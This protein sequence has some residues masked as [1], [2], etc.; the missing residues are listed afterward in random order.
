LPPNGVVGALA[1]GA[2]TLDCAGGADGCVRDGGFAGRAPLPAGGVD[3]ALDG[4][5]FAA[6]AAPAS[7]TDARGASVRGVA[8][9]GDGAIAA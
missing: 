6:I 5:G 3:A 2:A 7:A 8:V 1:A 4:A 9:A